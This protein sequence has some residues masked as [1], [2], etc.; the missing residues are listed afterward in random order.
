LPA[1][2]GD[3]GYLKAWHELVDPLSMEFRPDLILLSAGYDAHLADPLA[4]Q[5]VSTRGYAELSRRLLALALN[6]DRNIVAF[7]EGGYNTKALS[8]SVLATMRVLNADSLEE[9]RAVISAGEPKQRAGE[10]GLTGDAEPA[11]VDERIQEVKAH[12]SRYW[13]ALV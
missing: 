3:R 2:T 13:Q 7:L 5:G 6:M 1:G 9:A 12:L 11:L 8:E 4:Q 10:H